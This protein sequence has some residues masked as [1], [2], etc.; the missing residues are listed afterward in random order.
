MTEK[1]VIGFSSEAQIPINVYSLI[2]PVGLT[3][4]NIAVQV[5]TTTGPAA[6]A[7]PSASSAGTTVPSDFGLRH[8][9]VPSHGDL[10]FDLG[11]GI[12]KIKADSRILS[13]NSP[14]INR[15]TNT[16]GMKTL[17]ADDFSKEAVDCFIEACYTGRVDGL[18]TVNFRDVNKMS[19][20]FEVSWMSENCKD[21]FKSFVRSFRYDINVIDVLFV[22]NE[23]LYVAKALKQNHFYNI[24]V[25]RLVYFSIFDKNNFIRQFLVDINS[26][27]KLQLDLCLTVLHDDVYVLAELLEKHLDQGK[28]YNSFGENCRYLLYCIGSKSSEDKT[29]EVCDKLFDILENVKCSTNEDY[30]LLV[31]LY[32]QKSKQLKK[33]L[34]S[35]PLN[36]SFYQDYFDGDNNLLVDKLGSS[37]EVDSIYSF[38]DGLWSALINNPY[39]YHC[40][41]TEDLQPII[42]IKKKRGWGKISLSYLNRL[43]SLSYRRCR[44][45]V[46]NIKDCDELVDRGTEMKSTTICEYPASEFKETIFCSCK[47]FTFSLEGEHFELSIQATAKYTRP[48]DFCAKWFSHGQKCNLHFALEVEF[49]RGIR[50]W[51]MVPLTWFGPPT[52]FFNGREWNWG[53]IHFFDWSCK[54]LEDEFPRNRFKCFVK[55][56]RIYLSKRGYKPHGNENV[57]ILSTDRKCRLIAFKID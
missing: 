31:F 46:D 9:G 26:A 44:D 45:L 7:V 3:M 48:D 14:V 29:F 16:L 23:A 53:N 22:V 54:K 6:T 43:Y 33:N 5:M 30:R 25:E 21:Y 41:S 57:I 13:L 10:T 24:V 55:Y 50:R 34:L 27:S 37:S 56:N 32:K 12:E 52:C 51:H 2:I 18:N 1:N 47:S 42:N 40:C 11:V 4:I 15:L 8:I 20:A 19:H 17:A 28:G 36:F 49:E 39:S 38:F 35:Y